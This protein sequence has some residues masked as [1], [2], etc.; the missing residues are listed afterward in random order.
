M[1]AKMMP[2]RKEAVQPSI[3]LEESRQGRMLTS[4]RLR[5][6]RKLLLFVDQLEQQAIMECRTKQ[7]DA[8]NVTNGGED[9]E[10]IRRCCFFEKLELGAAIEEAR[11]SVKQLKYVHN[12]THMHGFVSI[13]TFGFR[14][15]YM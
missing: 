5:A 10:S 8:S 1:M 3:A 6:Q 2:S 11:E 7:A 13:R 9:S 15:Q 4:M 14:P 12:T